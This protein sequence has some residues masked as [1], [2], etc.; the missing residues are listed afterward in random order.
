MVLITAS[1][2][3]IASFKYNVT[4][5]M[6]NFWL[7]MSRAWKFDATDVFKANVTQSQP[8]GKGNLSR[9]KYCR[10][11]VGVE[12]LRQ[13]QFQITLKKNSKSSY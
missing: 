9:I 13:S 2:I 3:L 6:P 11:V 8:N 5:E 7:Y 10:W 4:N 1:K 12:D